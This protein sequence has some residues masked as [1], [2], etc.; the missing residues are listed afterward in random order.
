MMAKANQMKYNVLIHCGS[1][2]GTNW[3]QSSVPTGSAV[4]RLSYVTDSNLPDFFEFYK[5][6]I[7]MTFYSN[8]GRIQ[9]YIW[10]TV[11]SI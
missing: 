6:S 2:D 8:R 10:M 5:I 3:D 4:A 9:A 7:Q 1:L 11:L